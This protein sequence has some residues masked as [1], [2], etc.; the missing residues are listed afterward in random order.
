MKNKLLAAVALSLLV[1]NPLNAN[2]EGKNGVAAVV[3]G[4]K[5]TVK[6]LQQ[7][8]KDNPQI[9]ARVNFDDFYAKAL[10]VYV[11]GKLLYQAAEAAEVIDTPEYKKQ[12]QNAK[13]ELARKIYL[14]KKVEKK[15]SQAEIDKAYA[16]Y[17][18]TFKGDKEI[19][20]KHILVDS[21]TKAKEVITKLKK[22]ENFDTLAKQYS[23]EPADLGYF[24]KG[25]MVPEFGEAAFKLSKG[26][27]SKEPVKTQFGYHVILVEDTR[28]AKPLP[29]KEIEPQLKGLLTQKAV[30]EVFADLF[31]NAKI[32]RYSLDGKEIADPVMQAPAAAAQAQ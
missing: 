13:E 2:A 32:T 22:G 1:L 9:N 28:V 18:D 12:L 25:M 16:Q 3:N 30:G 14:E 15:I 17:K 27:Y 5:I 23:K 8:Y 31:K 4:E 11:N 10:D 26:K 19:K 29:K 24:T 20:A 6:E 7:G 21:E